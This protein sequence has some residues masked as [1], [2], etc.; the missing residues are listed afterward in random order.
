MA[1]PLWTRVAF[2][3]SG[4][5][6]VGAAV[7]MEMIGALLVNAFGFQSLLYAAASGVEEGRRCSARFC[8][9]EP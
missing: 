7:G 8:S 1:Q 9:S 5:V 6:Y 3:V 4:V 2:I